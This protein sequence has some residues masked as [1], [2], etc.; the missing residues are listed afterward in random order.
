MEVLLFSLHHF[1]YI[2][3]ILLL[4]PHSY[5]LSFLLL[6]PSLELLL[7]R[8]LLDLGLEHTRV[9]TQQNAC[10]ISKRHKGT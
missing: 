9:I 6:P 8:K 3:P 1:G 7:A 5:S 2:M 10:S 4:I